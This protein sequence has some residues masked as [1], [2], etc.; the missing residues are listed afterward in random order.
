MHRHFASLGADAASDDALMARLA[1]RDPVAFR[2][3]V[4]RH[5]LMIR[6]IGYR[7][8]GDPSEAE[9]VA[10]E[11]LARLWEHAGRWRPGGT[12]IGAWLHRV[13]V[14]ACL[15]R[16]RRRR[17]VSSGD[18]P[19]RADDAPIADALIDA[20][21]QRATVAACVGALADRQRAAIVLTYYEGLS[22]IMAADALD[23]NIKAFESLLHRA[24][25]TLHGSLRQAGL[26]DPSVRQVA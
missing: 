15:D 14:N 16:I 1:A 8:L 23:M 17:F 5:A 7:M 9:D 11:A 13:S 6:R 25:R 4:D 26:V 20:E 18:L 24:R 3:V 10:Q 12:G 22:N 19:D 2:M 21:Q